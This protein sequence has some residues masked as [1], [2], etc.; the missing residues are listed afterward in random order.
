MK[1]LRL[2]IVFKFWLIAVSAQDSGFLNNLSKFIENTAVYEQGQEEARAFHIPDQNI[3]LNGPWKFFYSDVPEGIP[4]DFFKENFDDAKWNVIAVPSNWEM[5][6]YGDRMF[7][8]ISLGYPS[9]KTEED[10]K[11]AGEF[12]VVPPKVPK[13]YNPTGA[14]RKVFELPGNWD[15]SEVFLHFEKVSSA[16]FVWV[17]GKEVGYNEGAQEPSEYNITPYLKKG[18]NTVAVFVMKFSDG[19]YL[20]GQDYWRLAGIFDDVWVYA[21]PKIRLFDWQVITDFDKF[22]TDSRLQLNVDIKNYGLQA[23]GYKVRA[24]LHKDGLQVAAFES[25]DFSLGKGKKTV[26][27]SQLIKRPEKWTSETP[28]LYDLDI[29]LLDNKGELADQIKTRIGFKKTE[30]IGN[31]F[32][33]NGVPVKLNGTNT[34]MQTPEGGHVVDEATI[35]KDLEILKQFNFNLVRISH[36]PPVNRY[37]ELADEYGLF[38]VDEVGDES[39][40]TQYVCDMPEYTEMYKDRARKC[41]LRDRNHPSIL[42]WSAG[43][44]SGEGQNIT[45]VV[46]LGKILDPT[47]YWM[48]GGNDM[49]HPAEDII[50]PRYPSPLQEEVNLGLDTTDKRPSFMDEY[51]SVTGNGGGAL[52]DYWRVIYRHPRIMGGAIWD[53]VSNGLTDS[54]RIL[55]DESPYS[56]LVTAM[57]NSKLVKG[58]SGMAIDLNGHDE[59]VEV[60]QSESLDISGDQL[61]I[62]MDVFPRILNRSSGT[63]LAKGNN[64]YGLFQ[65][66]KDSLNFYIFTQ[67][68]QI[69]SASLPPDWENY[70]HH[71]EAVYDGKQMK[72]FIDKNLVAAKEVKGKIKNLPY[73]VNIGRNAETQKQDTKVYVCDAKIDKVRIFAKAIEEGAEVKPSDAVLW[74]DFESDTNGGTFYSNGMGARTYGSIWPNRKPQ[75]EL[76]QMKKSPQPLSFKMLNNEKGILEAWNRSNYTNAS[77]WETVWKLTEDDKVLQNG[78]LK[79]DLSPGNKQQVIVPYKKPQ[80]VPGKEYRLTIS[81]LLKQDEIWAPK[82][83]EVSWDQFELKDWNIAKVNVV[84]TAKAARLGSIE[85]SYIVTGD[86]F[87]YA[88]NK[89]TGELQSMLLD[90]EEMLASPLKLNVWRAPVSNQNDR[91]AGYQFKTEKWKE[92]YGRTMATDLYSSGIDKLQFLPLEVSADE[93]GGN[94]NIYVRE[95]ALAKQDENNVISLAY[96]IEGGAS[97]ALGGFESM[98]TYSIS[99]DGILTVDHT[100]LPQGTMPQM[101]PRIGVTLMVDNSLNQV[102]WYGRGPQ[103]NYPD[104]KTG[105]RIGIY[106]SPVDSLYEPYLVPQDYGLRTDN[107]YVEM[108][109]NQGRGLV[110]S[111]D[112]YFNFNVSSFSTENIT[113]AQYIFQLKKA[114]GITLNLDYESSGV[115]DTAQPVLDSYRVYPQGY[116]RK[117]VIKPVK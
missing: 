17:N 9:G 51:L 104:R 80:I 110:F 4:S 21:A 41:V 36:Y 28:V 8:N 92:E 22:Y 90:G 63:F 111:M 49:V 35:R 107:R 61:T 62:M 23:K 59:W 77:Y 5:K 13:E 102:K 76:W 86:G 12:A 108:T 97:G 29:R 56:T 47:R 103:E 27:L 87:R 68:K 81:S 37:L 40:A 48:Y 7:R 99:G 54:V 3:L 89:T 57:G 91:W 60:Y 100:V 11:A 2:L 14:Y 109:N 30:I 113:R 25:S 52:D 101:L 18:K 1:K 20:E 67:K 74:L 39:H 38:I 66:G 98:Y 64:Q 82:G 32:Y 50:G 10:K 114:K 33:L 15:G 69:I 72:L 42:F 73:P 58:I 112:Q 79:F 24:V 106:H 19:Y 93:A 65:S 83:H 115:G 70:W 71:I 105:Y 6:G 117:I 44:E 116:T 43:N 16:S 34:H 96:L 26:K 31:V 53:F 55:K 94:V 95:V 78:I 75:P 85:N 84:P 45:E 88:F 46:K